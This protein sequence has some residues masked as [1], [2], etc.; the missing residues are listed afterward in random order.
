MK[1]LKI[2]QKAGTAGK[3]KKWI[4]IGVAVVVII[5]GAMTVFGKRKTDVLP[6]VTVQKVVKQ[7]VTSTVETSGTVESLKVK[8]YFSPVNASISSLPYQM[9][10]VVKKG[11]AL[12]SFETDSLEQDNEKSQL[13]KTATVNGS[14][15]TAQKAV[16]S[17]QKV[18][19]AQEELPTLEQNVKNY[20]EYVASLKTAISDRTRSL[21]EDSSKASSDVSVE[22][23]KAQ[24]ELTKMQENMSNLTALQ[25][26][27]ETKITELTTE[28]SEMKKEG[29]DVSEAEKQLNNL[30][31]AL[32]Q[33][34]NQI[35]EQQNYIDEQNDTI[36][37]LN[38]R[39]IEIQNNTKDASSDEQIVAWQNE[40]EDATTKLSELQS[41]LSEKKT[42]AEGSTDAELTQA[43]KDQLEATDNLAELE[44]S[45]TQELLEKGRQ[46]IKADF[47]GIIS[48]E[49][50]SEG[51]AATQGMELVTVSSNE[52]VAVN[53]SVSKYDYDKLKEG[54][55][56]SIVIAGN[57]YTGSVSSI[58]KVAVTNEKGAPVIS[59]KVKIE[60]PDENIFL[61]VEAKVS[62]QTDTAKNVVCVPASAVN[63]A[64]DSTFC[65]ILKDGVV[66]KQKITTGV[67]A[68]DYI[69]VTNG[70][71]AGDEVISELPKGVEEGMAAEVESQNTEE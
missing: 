18:K 51:T 32:K 11:D 28:V 69:E 36:T 65:Y 46:G 8:T 35:K 58:S 12:V 47:A 13:N 40:L 3:K 41:E 25:Q 10:D 22:L 30:N 17:A 67:V 37:Q 27:Q 24:A 52:E 15:D 45:S 54:Q 70:L 63:T 50:I 20:Q 49:E 2:K 1:K 68:S 39:Q 19:D 4:V 61:G 56:A 38:V 6:Q 62:I 64:T 48:K 53:V 59:A 60:N 9:G 43:A 26:E 44:A 21:T 23:T 42:V 5:V 29:G 71:K 55:K 14:K 7:D 16:E 66:T 34:K 57:T 33:T 31:D